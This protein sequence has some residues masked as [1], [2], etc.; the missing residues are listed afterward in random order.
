MKPESSRASE[1]PRGKANLPKL[2]NSGCTTASHAGL[3][4]LKDASRSMSSSLQNARASSSQDLKG[5]YVE[6]ERTMKGLH[7]P[8][9]RRQFSKTRLEGESYLSSSRYQ[10]MAFGNTDPKSFGQDR[11]GSDLRDTSFSSDPDSDST[12]PDLKSGGF[13]N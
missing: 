13:S 1:Q 12:I 4:V 2:L 5:Y 8:D 9:L 7:S 3:N 10:K 6:K 11:S